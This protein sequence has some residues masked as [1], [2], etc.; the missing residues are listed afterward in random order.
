VAIPTTRHP[1]C[2]LIAA[3]VI[4]GEQ[5][6]GAGFPLAALG[7]FG[8]AASTVAAIYIVGLLIL[9]FA[10]ETKGHPLSE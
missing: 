10:P 5:A 9:S 3:L 8:R 1:C 6:A 4:G 7:G 2:R